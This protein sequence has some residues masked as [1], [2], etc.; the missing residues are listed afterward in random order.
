MASQKQIIEKFVNSLLK[1]EEIRVDKGTT[2][3]N[4]LVGRLTYQDELRDLLIEPPAYFKE[5]QE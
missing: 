2:S 1:G 3:L 5:I 4:L